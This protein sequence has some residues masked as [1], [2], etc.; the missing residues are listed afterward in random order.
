MDSHQHSLDI[1]KELLRTSF[2]FFEGD[3]KYREKETNGHG[4]AVV[5]EIQD[6]CL[7]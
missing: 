3:K 4:R 7:A 1:R 5:Q 6:I 2:Q